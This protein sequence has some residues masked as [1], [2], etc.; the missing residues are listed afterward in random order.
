VGCHC[1]GAGARLDLPVGPIIAIH[2]VTVGVN[3]VE[4]VEGVDFDV[5]NH[6]TL[7]RSNGNW[8][9]RW[10]EITVDLTYGADPPS[11]LAAAAGRYAVELAKHCGGQECA[12]DPA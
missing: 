7:V 10:E 3:A 8:W 4:M 5:V 6:A 1:P 9:P 11:F 2:S 12:F